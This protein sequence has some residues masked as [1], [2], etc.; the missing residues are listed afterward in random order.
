[1]RGAPRSRSRRTALRDGLIIGIA[2]GSIFPL[3]SVWGDMVQKLGADGLIYWATDPGNPYVNSSVA[4]TDGPG[5][6]LYSPAFLH[7]LLP[8]K[9]LPAQAFSIIWV[10]IGV[11]CAIWLARSWPLAL[12][13]LWFPILQDLMIG[14]MHL[15]MAAVI[16]AGFRYPAAWALVLLTKVTPGVGLLWFLV[17]REW[18]SLSVAIGVTAAIAGV[19]FVIAPQSWFGWLG[20]LRNDGASQAVSVV[21][22]LAIAAVIVTWGAWTSRPWTV[23]VASMVAA[24][25]IYSDSFAIL[26]AALVLAKD[27]SRFVPALADRATA[28]R[29]QP[30]GIVSSQPSSPS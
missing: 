21:P 19:S 1:M 13:V 7:L 15:L 14:N 28:P 17:R 29:S 23:P 25:V 24:P 12:V 10:A 16:A 27:P 9:V 30:G 20:L 8:L 18:R 11:G 5:D 22:R 3:I 4:G 2:V 6:Y 26:L